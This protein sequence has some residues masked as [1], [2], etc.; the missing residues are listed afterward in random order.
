MSDTG[1][2]S[3]QKTT[4][5]A[6]GQSDIANLNA[7][8]LNPATII[9]NGVTYDISPNLIGVGG[10]SQVYKAY[11]RE[12]GRACAAKIDITGRML[13]PTERVNR[14]QI[15]NFLRNHNEYKEYHILP[16]LASG[17][18]TI[19]AE[20]GF[21]MQYPVDIFPYCADG[22]LGSRQVKYSFEELKNRIIPA[23][24]AALKATHDAGLIHRDV[25]PKNIF[26]YNGEIVLADYGTAIT[27]EIGSKDVAVNTKLA[28]GTH[29]YKAM[30]VNSQF[31]Q[32][33]SDYFSLGCTLA[34]LYN[35]KHPYEAILQSDEH[36]M[37]YEQVNRHGLQLEYGKGDESLKD[38]FDALTR[39]NTSERIGYDGIMLWTRDYKAFCAKYI[40][41]FKKTS[42]SSSDEWPRV[43]R[44][45]DKEYHNGK[46][47]AKALKTNW[48]E[49]TG[50]LYRGR[51]NNFF[52]WDQT[53]QNRIDK[54]V[55]IDEDTV[56]NT[57]LGLARFLHYLSKEPAFCWRN[58]EFAELSEVSEMFFNAEA[59][60]N[61]HLINEISE[62][63]KSGYVSWKIDANVQLQG[64]DEKNNDS[65]K[66]IIQA[67]QQIE[68][69]AKKRPLLA[70]NY[71]ALRW[72]KN[73]KY[74]S[75]TNK[76]CDDLFEDIIQSAKTPLI[77]SEKFLEIMD[78]VSLW[79]KVSNN[80]FS[81]YVT[82]ML[83]KYDEDS[84][85]SKYNCFY[86]LFEQVC[87]DKIKV[88]DHFRN[89]SPDAYLYWLK[90]NLSLYNFNS[91]DAVLVKTII[92]G[93]LIS[94][95]MPLTEL[96]ESFRKLRGFFSDGG[97]FM[98][99]FQGD[100][101]LAALGFAKGKNRHGEITA[102]HA[103]AFFI[104][105]FFEQKVPQGFMKSIK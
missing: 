23:L 93:T 26:E 4:K 105:T 18:L 32:K 1:V 90:N 11:E 30:E 6:T 56:R 96:R 78:D 72:N 10:E 46:D 102:N 34:T 82:E 67:V 45:E 79:A 62:M 75:L 87:E 65:V 77:F 95:E 2:M 9:E 5:M 41:S 16:L 104:D 33:A 60:G 98:S 27:T 68:S 55:N 48:G 40:D 15:I 92:E 103:D 25:K 44:F 42:S 73:P 7:V 8:L 22:D 100:I 74:V 39:L 21:P 51:F 35:G 88:R 101:V 83:D 94:S 76:S 19:D 97:D 53:M 17:Y 24:S 31:V 57:D 84:K 81:A 85:T 50:Y 69:T 64:S 29:G 13:N 80:G 14:R 99:L 20:D 37:F 91:S 66:L 86:D 89:N 52:E 43:Y 70:A 38:L 54:I 12:S 3:W 61:T 63:L 49:A 71:A 28:R 36:F 58:I 59:A 47:L